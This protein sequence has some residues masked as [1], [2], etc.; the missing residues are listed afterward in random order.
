M[1]KRP[2]LAYALAYLWEGKGVEQRPQRLQAVVDSQATEWHEDE[3]GETEG[4]EE[5]CPTITVFS[6][7][8]LASFRRYVLMVHASPACLC[9]DEN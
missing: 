1:F 9:W 5:L 7:H 8:V 4:E 3:T 6:P 2:S